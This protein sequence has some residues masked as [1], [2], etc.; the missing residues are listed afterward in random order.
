[1]KDPCFPLTGFSLTKSYIYG[2]NMAL[3][4]NLTIPSM[5]DA[6]HNEEKLPLFFF[7]PFVIIQKV[8]NFKTTNFRTTKIARKKIILKKIILKRNA[9]FFEKLKIISVQ[10]ISK[11]IVITSFFG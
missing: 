8:E 3:L 4:K 10:I 7:F 1:M 2:L 9:H 5:A 6:W 11:R